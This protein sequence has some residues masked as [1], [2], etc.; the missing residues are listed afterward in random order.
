[1]KEDKTVAVVHLIWLP[2]GIELFKNFVQ[3]Y[4]K[5]SPGYSHDLII[6]FNGVTQKDE[7]SD[8][9]TFLK[10]Q[11]IEYHSYYLKDGLD[12]KAYHWIALQLTHTYILFLNSY[13]QL[14]APDWLRY[15]IEA[16]Q[17]EGTGIA[18]A[19]GSW[20][21]HYTSVFTNNR[22]KWDT[23]KT[24][25][26]N[27]RKYKLFIKAVVYWFFLFKPFPNPHVRTSSFMMKRELF[28]R[29]SKREVK[30]KF[31]AYLFESGRRGLSNQLLKKGFKMLVIDKYGKT[32]EIKDWPLSSTFRINDQ[33]NLL[34]SDNRTRQF[35]ES[36]VKEQQ[37]LTYLAW[38]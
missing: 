22:F 15:F 7:T 28:I 19:T 18:G 1:M 9:H 11:Q 35:E 14:L 17:Q 20:Q 4:K 12:I 34:I 31:G 6:L 24:F 37:K 21:S 16:M 38:G 10:D 13:V 3:S 25:N 2:F 27:Y 23:E 30:N 32:Y 33:K 29:F 26:E 36:T 8:F 5:Y